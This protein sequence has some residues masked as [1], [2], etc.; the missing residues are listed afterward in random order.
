MQQVGRRR[1]GKS[2]QAD[3]I[4]ERDERLRALRV[5]A[6]GPADEDDEGSREHIAAVD[7][8]LHQD[9]TPERSGAREIVSVTV[10][11]LM[12]RS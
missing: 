9:G 10:H 8:A 7:C 3:V 1:H 4:E 5:R 11:R 12:T 2:R 6:R